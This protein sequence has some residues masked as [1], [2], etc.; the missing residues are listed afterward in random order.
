VFYSAWSDPAVV[1]AGDP[2]GEGVRPVTEEQ[3]TP[4]VLDMNLNGRVLTT[5]GAMKNV[6]GFHPLN[7]CPAMLVG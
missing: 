7:G 2:G 5:S 4:Q 6:P 1:G 3:G